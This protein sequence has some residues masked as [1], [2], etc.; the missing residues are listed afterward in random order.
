MCVFCKR[1]TISRQA[2]MATVPVLSG[3]W[4]DPSL[5]FTMILEYK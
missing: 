5:A 3:K 2:S 1:F 4:M